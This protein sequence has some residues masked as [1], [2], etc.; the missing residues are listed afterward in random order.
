MDMDSIDACSICFEKYNEECLRPHSLPC[1][2][3]CCASCLDKNIKNGELECPYCKQVYKASKATDFPIN[4]TVES[5]ISSLRKTQLN[6]SFENPLKSEDYQQCHGSNASAKWQA[7]IKEQ[8]NNLK[9]LL[10]DS[11]SM[12]SEIKKYLE[13]LQTRKA[14]HN[15]LLVNIY[16]LATLNEDIVKELTIEEER[17]EELMKEQEENREIALS[18]L[19]IYQNVTSTSDAGMVSEDLENYNQILRAWIGRCEQL[20]NPLVL[21][22][23]ETLK[24][25]TESAVDKVPEIELLEV[26]P[27]DVCLLEPSLNIME[28]LTRI[29]D[30][31]ILKVGDRVIRGRDW[32]WGSQDGHSPSKGTVIRDQGNGWLKVKWDYG[33]ENAYRM[34]AEGC[35]D[36]KLVV[37]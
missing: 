33:S 12:V 31:Q 5:I 6:E 7:L 23:S 36:L 14:E 22:N 29:K 15:S 4:Y 26:A 21:K 37:A 9:S 11:G 2:H 13:F 25:Y 1:G 27:A 32:K 18:K 28:K 19:G 20:P 17:L 24:T 30:V 16:L 34:G 8:R 35:F 10:N 3:S